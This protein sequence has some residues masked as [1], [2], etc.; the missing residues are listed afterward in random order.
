[1]FF[2]ALYNLDKIYLKNIIEKRFIIAALL[3]TLF[4]NCYYLH[5]GNN[6]C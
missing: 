4:Y 3:F 5:C 1:M 2:K 6:C